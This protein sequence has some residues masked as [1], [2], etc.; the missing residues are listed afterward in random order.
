M[1]RTYQPFAVMVRADAGT[2]RGRR[3]ADVLPWTAGQG[4]RDG[5]P[6]AY[7]CRSFA[8]ERPAADATE[9]LARLSM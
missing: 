8:C 4:M 6:T 7:V 2:D 5:R 3:V 9:L 1:D